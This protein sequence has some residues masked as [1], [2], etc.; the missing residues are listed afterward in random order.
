M[1]AKKIDIINNSTSSQKALAISAQ[2]VSKID[3]AVSSHLVDI[4]S[5]STDN[6]DEGSKNSPS[7]LTY[8]HT[9]LTNVVFERYDLALKNLDEIMEIEKK[10]PTFGATAKRYITHSKS[11]VKAMKSKREIG[12]LPQISKSKQKELLNILR[13]VN[14]IWPS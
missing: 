2:R 5:N 8:G 14:L 13:V 12:K 11:L 6:G 1:G 7:G 3:K 9:V 10:F 4:L